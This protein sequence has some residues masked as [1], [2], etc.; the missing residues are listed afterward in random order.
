MPRALKTQ[1]IR[2]EFIR[3][4][5]ERGYR[6]V[7]SAL[8]SLRDPTPLATS[9]GMVQF[10]PFYAATGNLE[11][12][13]AASVQKCFGPPT[14]SGSVIPSASLLLRDAG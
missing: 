14:S 2:D 5:V 1:E 13:R 4:F 9:A 6:H 12:T 10:K 7:P 8:W 3:F 11:A